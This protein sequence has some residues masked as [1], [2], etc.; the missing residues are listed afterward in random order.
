ME[1]SAGIPGRNRSSGALAFSPV[2]WSLRE[3]DV[4]RE[5]VDLLEGGLDFLRDFDFGIRD[6]SNL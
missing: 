2:S 6:L 5:V 4:W 1:S 3:M